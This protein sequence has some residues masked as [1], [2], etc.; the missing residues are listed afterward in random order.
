[1]RPGRT[2]LADTPGVPEAKPGSSGDVRQRTA[3]RSHRSRVRIAARR[4]K[5]GGMVDTITDGEHES[6]GGP[7]GA[8]RVAALPRQV[9]EDLTRRLRRNRRAFRKEDVQVVEPP[10]LRRAVGASALG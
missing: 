9:R 6:P 7:K 4:K 2:C 3:E 8:K 10:L 5:R 1:M